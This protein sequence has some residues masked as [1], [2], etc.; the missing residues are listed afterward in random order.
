M[1]IIESTG[2]KIKYPAVIKR[3]NAD[4]KLLRLGIMFK[5]ESSNMP[6]VRKRR[7]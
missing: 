1:L 3:K 4:T 2:S 7:L 5:T 6:A